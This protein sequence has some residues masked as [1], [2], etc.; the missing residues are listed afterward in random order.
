ML[1]GGV[2]GGLD[3]IN[4]CF[5]HDPQLLLQSVCVCVCVCVFGGL[6][7]FGR[8]SQINRYFPHMTLYFFLKGLMMMMMMM[9]VCVQVCVSVYVHVSVCKPVW[10]CKMQTFHKGI[11]I[12]FFSPFVF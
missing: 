10:I 3:H 7:G 9:I 5:L 8:G 12:F 6:E 2:G 4:K 11:Y 1:Q